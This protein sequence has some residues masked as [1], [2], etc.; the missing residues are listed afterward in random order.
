MSGC[1][2]ISIP[3]YKD[4]TLSKSQSPNNKDEIK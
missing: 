4:I 3:T 2:A 1:K